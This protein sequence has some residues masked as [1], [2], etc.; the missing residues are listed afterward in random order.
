VIQLKNVKVEFHL[1]G[2]APQLFEYM[3]L[4]PS[5]IE[6]PPLVVYAHG[7]PHSSFTNEYQ[8]T[9][10]FLNLI[11][12]AVILLNY[13][14]S[15]GFGKKLIDDLAGQIGTMDV[16]DC[17]ESI[18][19][20]VNQ[21]KV[22]ADKIVYIGGSHGGFLGGH[23]LALD[24]RIKAAVIRNP[25]T[26]I[27]SMYGVTDIPD[28]CSTMTNSTSLQTMFDVSPMSKLDKISAPT[29]FLLGD[30]DKRVPISQGIQM[31]HAL[32]AQGVPTGIKMYP[33]NGHAI[34]K[35]E[36][37]ADAWVNAALWYKKYL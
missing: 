12:Y 21:G 29:L 34:S 33:K 15:L 31:Y 19:H 13:R 6:K 2:K 16:N 23:I 32:K 9:V 7:G 3:S 20:F 5:N 17:I 24:K 36:C 22:N 18:T 10:S 11:G 30:V 8:H 25:V 27:A 28:W 1:L 14:G 4:V 35:A 37:E 26:N